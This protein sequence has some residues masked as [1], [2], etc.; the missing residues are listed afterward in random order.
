MAGGDDAHVA[1]SLRSGGHPLS[2]TWEGNLPA[3]AAQFAGPM[4]GMLT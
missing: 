3:E 4:M 2:K 1:A